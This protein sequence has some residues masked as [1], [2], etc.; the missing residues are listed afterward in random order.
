LLLTSI[1]DDKEVSKEK[2][3]KAEQALLV[4]ESTNESRSSEIKE[5]WRERNLRIV[6]K[7]KTVR[8]TEKIIDQINTVQDEAS[9]VLVL[10]DGCS[11]KRKRGMEKVYNKSNN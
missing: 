1:K 5:F 8:S 3:K 6:L 10:E 9:D 4:Y 7:E 2:R 11:N